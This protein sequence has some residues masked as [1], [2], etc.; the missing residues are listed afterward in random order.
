MPAIPILAA[1][2]GGSALAGGAALAS[3]A[4]GAYSTLKGAS[5]AKKAAAAAN[6]AAQNAQVDIGA[7]SDMATQQAL[8]NIELSRAT[9]LENNPE[10]AAL[11]TASIIN[12]LGQL[13]ADTTD[14]QNI[15]RGQ[16]GRSSRTPLLDQ[17]VAKAS[18]D[19]ALGG[20]IPLDVRNLVAR[21]AAAKAGRVGAVRSGR[22]ISARDLGLTSLDLEQRRLTNARDIAGLDVEATQFDSNYLLNQAQMIQALSS[23]DFGRALALAQFGQSLQAPVVGLDP[24]SVANLAVG[25]SNASTAAG[26]TAAQIAAAQAQGASQ[27]GGA[28]LGAGLGGIVNGYSTPKKP[29]VATAAKANTVGPA[30]GPYMP[31][32]SPFTYGKS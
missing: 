26:M 27:L 22:D 6:Q 10:N 3:T 13:G 32:Y 12:L 25:N 21:N 4:I 19:L 29:V 16:L 15:I 5:D 18:S 31:F 17:T 20:A 23:G 1:V 2:G 30:T 14:V 28:L 24:A 11:R 7:V 9:E 8:K